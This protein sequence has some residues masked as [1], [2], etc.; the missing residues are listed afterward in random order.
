MENIDTQTNRRSLASFT[1]CLPCVFQRKYLI[2]SAIYSVRKGKEVIIS[3]KL[4][5]VLHSKSPSYPLTTFLG[6]LSGTYWK[7]LFR[8]TVSAAPLIFFFKSL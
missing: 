3:V 5:V 2:T 8:C 7:L 6:D 1:A 4:F